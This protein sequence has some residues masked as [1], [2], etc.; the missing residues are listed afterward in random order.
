[1]P[2]FKCNVSFEFWCPCCSRELVWPGIPNE[3]NTLICSNCEC[4]DRT[5]WQLSPSELAGFPTLATL[6]AIGEREPK[7]K[8]TSE[9]FRNTLG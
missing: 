7:I 5:L 1:M 8:I 2:S 4:T 9:Q 3:P 6:T